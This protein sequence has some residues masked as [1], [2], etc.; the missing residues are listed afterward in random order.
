MMSVMVADFA[1]SERLDRRP[2]RTVTGSA[3]GRTRIEDLEA[4]LPPTYL[5]H[6]A[7][8]RGAGFLAGR[9]SRR[10]RRTSGARRLPLPEFTGAT[11]RFAGTHCGQG[12]QRATGSTF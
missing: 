11:L 3:L 5:R 8:P 10:N 6:D 7:L 4:A 2:L 9:C 1:D 12:I